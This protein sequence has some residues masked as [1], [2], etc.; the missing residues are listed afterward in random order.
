M[1]THI[2]RRAA[3][4]LFGARPATPDGMRIGSLLDLMHEGFHLLFLLKTGC[5]PPAEDDFVPRIGAFLDDFERE[6]KKLRADGEDIEAAKYAWCAALDE[7]MLASSS[8]L[9]DRWETHPLQ[10]TVFGDQLAG[11]HFFDRLDALRG[12]GG[13]RL[14]ALQVFHMCLLL[15]FRGKH[16]ADGG[17]RLAYMTARLGDE[18]AH[19]KGRVAGFAPRAGR[20]DQVMHKLRSDVPL[21]AV[22]AVFALAGLGVFTGLRTALQRDTQQAMA[23]YAGLVKLAPRPASLTITLP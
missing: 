1:T 5:Q 9:R 16:A 20:P 17:D 11:E 8:P 15:G 4:S 23:A 10:L 13:T 21:W 19:L 14:Q 12:K 18:I 2:E 22:C 7:T 6:A 3:P